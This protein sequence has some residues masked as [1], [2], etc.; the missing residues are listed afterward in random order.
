MIETTPDMT[1]A[2][3]VRLEVFLTHAQKAIRTQQQP[4]DRVSLDNRRATGD[5]SGN[6]DERLVAGYAPRLS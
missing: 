1:L 4:V 6:A 5:G 2:A 3:I